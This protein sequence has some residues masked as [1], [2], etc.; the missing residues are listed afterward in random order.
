MDIPTR[1]RQLTLDTIIA[2]RPWTMCTG[3]IHQLPAFLVNK[4]KSK[5][6][7]WHMVRRSLLFCV[8]Y[9]FSFNRLSSNN[10]IGMD[11]VHDFV[12]HWPALDYPRGNSL[13]EGCQANVN[14]LSF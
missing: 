14:Y 8:V 13:A 3:E 4:L 12:S 5:P 1:L 9:K 11:P 6:S 2:C 10:D 7:G